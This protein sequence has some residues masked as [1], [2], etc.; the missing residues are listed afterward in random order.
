MRKLVSIPSLAASILWMS[1]YLPANAE[2]L[3][4]Y[5][6]IP[7]VLPGESYIRLFNTLGSETNFE[8]RAFDRATGIEDVSRSQAVNLLP[9][10]SKQMLIAKSPSDEEGASVTLYMRSDKANNQVVYQHVHYSPITG[11]F[12]NMTVCSFDNTFNEMQAFSLLNRYLVNVHTSQIVGYTSYVGLTNPDDQERVVRMIITEANGGEWI[13]DLNVT[14]PANGSVTMSF[15]EIEQAIDW[16]PTPGLGQYHANIELRSGDMDA[17]GVSLPYTAIP[18]HIVVNEATGYQSN[19]TQVC[20]VATSQE[21]V[22]VTGGTCH[23]N[24][25]DNDSGAVGEVFSPSCPIVDFP[26]ATNTKGRFNF[27]ISPEVPLTA[28][29]G[30]LEGDGD[31]DWY[32]V[33]LGKGNT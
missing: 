5:T 4:Q 22:D 1:M 24:L 19:T 15:P 25:G 30:T 13:G 23:P 26:A 10:T 27:G 32:R 29:D 14:I 9:G 17:L 7:N 8:I 18:S 21:P 31:V 6:P 33:P 11:N 3:S 2:D 20:R 16:Q 12:E 28:V